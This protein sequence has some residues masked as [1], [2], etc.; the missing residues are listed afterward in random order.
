MSNFI[1]KIQKINALA[2]ELLKQ[3]KAKDSI[4]AQQMAE[5]AIAGNDLED[6][7]KNARRTVDEFQ[8]YGKA[9][10][11]NNM[12]QPRDWKSKSEQK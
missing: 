3:G 6:F 2:S 12:K 10:K 1:E 4:E 5:A 11:D 7:N 9:V 8:A